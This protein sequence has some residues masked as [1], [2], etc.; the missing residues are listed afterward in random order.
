MS[1][2]S[3]SL[4]S[5]S[6]SL[7]FRAARSASW[8]SRSKRWLQAVQPTLPPAMRWTRLSRRKLNREIQMIAMRRRMRLLVTE[9]TAQY[10][11]MK[12]SLRLLKMAHQVAMK[13]QPSKTR[14][15]QMTNRTLILLMSQRLSRIQ[16]LPKTEASQLLMS[17]TKAWMP[18]TGKQ[19]LSRTRQMMEQSLLHLGKALKIPNHRAR[20][21]R[22]LPTKARLQQKSQPKQKHSLRTASL[23]MSQVRE[24]LTR[25]LLSTQRERAETLQMVQRPKTPRRRLETLRQIRALLLTRLRPR[26]QCPPTLPSQQTSRL[27]S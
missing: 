7:A 9:K 10:P 18:R 3:Y 4:C 11:M 21:N 20:S 13:M 17:K 2:S 16:I 24:Q 8:K 14:K 15:A 23:S 19:W 6:C 27:E 22:L 26:T 25:A 12:P 5:L 1:W